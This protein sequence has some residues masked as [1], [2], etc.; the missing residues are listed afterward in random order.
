MG[1]MSDS[2][3]LRSQPDYWNGMFLKCPGCRC[4]FQFSA[5]N[6]AFRYVEGGTCVEGS[7]RTQCHDCSQW[8]VMKH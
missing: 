2:L 1:S 6:D 3:D 7:A 5:L 8:V 4:R